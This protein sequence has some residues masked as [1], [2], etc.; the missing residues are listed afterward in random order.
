MFDVNNFK[1]RQKKWKNDSKK[2]KKTISKNET[3]P[4]FFTLVPLILVSSPKLKT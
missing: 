1:H 2:Q 3:N 4:I